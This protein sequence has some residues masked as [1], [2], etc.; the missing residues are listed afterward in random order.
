MKIKLTAILLAILL[1]LPGCRWRQPIQTPQIKPTQLSA[2]GNPSSLGDV[3]S[4]V[5]KLPDRFSGRN[6]GQIRLKVHDIKTKKTTEMSLNDYLCGVLAGEMRQDWPAEALKAQAIIARTFLMQFLTENKKSRV[7]PD[8]DVSTDPEESQAYDVSGV[9]DNIKKA[10]N[11][12]D[13]IVIAY[14]GQFIHAWFHSASGGKTADAV[15]GLNF[16]EGNPP[17]I[18]SVTSDESQVPK[19]FTDWQNSFTTDAITAALSKINIDVGG[20]ITDVKLGKT[21]PSGR[22]VTIVINGKDVPAPDFRV[23]MDPVKFRSTLITDLKFD[24][25]KLTVKGKGFGHGVGMPQWGAYQMANSGKKA[26]DIINYYFKGV[27]IVNLW[28]K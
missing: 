18:Q 25:K 4:V 15:E 6:P 9:N 17:Y 23:A 11:D 2:T 19:E 22:A 26:E 24:G 8:A 16:K 10:V 27:S 7:S 1:L 12:T 20:K 21:G 5:P 3:G 13:G 28:N 14:N